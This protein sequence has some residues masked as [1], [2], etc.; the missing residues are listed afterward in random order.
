V[1]GAGPVKI[2]RPL[3]KGFRPGKWL[4]HFE[5]HGQEFGAKNS[6]EYLQGALRLKNAQA[7]GDILRKYDSATGISRTYNRATNEF[8]STN[9]DGSI[10][11]YLKPRE[12][13]QYFDKQPGN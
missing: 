3:M 6:V 9:K 4:K 11:T 1:P 7:G 8:V 13:A 12:G 10:R 2:L 5:K